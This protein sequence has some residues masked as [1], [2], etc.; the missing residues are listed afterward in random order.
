[1]NQH[2]VILTEEG[3]GGGERETE[4]ETK[5]DRE[6]QRERERESKIGDIKA[7]KRGKRMT[8]MAHNKQEETQTHYTLYPIQVHTTH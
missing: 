7:D 5:G 6:R 8:V 1:M 4:T 3:R 2:Q